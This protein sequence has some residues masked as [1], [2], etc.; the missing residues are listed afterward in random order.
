MGEVGCGLLLADDEAVDLRPASRG[1]GFDGEGGLARLPVA[2]REP[3]GCE[4]ADRRA[5][6]DEHAAPVL[7]DHQALGLQQRQRVAHGHARDA[8]VLDELCFR[9][10]LFAFLQATAVDGFAQPV[11]DLPEDGPVA[12]GVE[13]SQVA[14]RVI[15]HI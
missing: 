2:S 14:V 1:F 4:S 3:V 15:W 6:A 7:G 5:G 13:R 9:R 11:G 10:E 8:V 12:R